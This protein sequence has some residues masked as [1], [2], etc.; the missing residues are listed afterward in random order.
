[1]RKSRAEK[2]GKIQ[3]H[4]IILNFPTLDFLVQKIKV[5]EIQNFFCRSLP[6]FSIYPDISIL[7]D[8]LVCISLT[9]SAIFHDILAVLNSDLSSE[10]L[11]GGGFFLLACCLGKICFSPRG[12]AVLLTETINQ[13]SVHR[14]CI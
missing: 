6:N 7:Y 1:M 12:F 5:W 13:R 11:F 3:I 14:N 8:I 10:G 9:V 2:S 4:N